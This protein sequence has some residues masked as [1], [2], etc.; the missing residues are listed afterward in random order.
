MT[1]RE[2]DILIRI[3]YPGIC[4]ICMFLA[5]LFKYYGVIQ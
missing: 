3:I 1:E 5:I 4:V 2:R